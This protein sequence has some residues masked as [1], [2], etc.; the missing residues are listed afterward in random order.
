MMF[1][2][3]TFLCM[4]HHPIILVPGAFRSQLTVT[5]E[6]QKKFPQC[7]NFTNYPFWISP[8]FLLPNKI[9]G[10]LYWLT[11]DYDENSKSII[12][13]PNITVKALDFG[14]VEGIKSTGKLFFL[15]AG[16]YNRVIKE[17]KI[18]NYVIGKNLF[19]APYDWRLGIA[20][21]KEF[22]TNLTHLVESAYNS[23]NIKVKFLTHSCGGLILHKFLTTE[24]TPEWRK[25]YIDSAVLSAPSFAGSGAS[26]VTL[27]RQRIPYLKF[28]KNDE[29]K[30]MIG[31]L[32]AFHLHIPNQ[33]IYENTTVFI[34]PENESIKA[35]QVVDF[36]IQHH[37]LT[38]KQQKIALENF[39]YASRFPTALDIPVMIQY[40]SGI[41]T[42]FGLNI[43]KWD[44]EGQIIYQKGDGIV[45]SEGIERICEQWKKEG[46]DIECFDINSSSIVNRHPFLILRSRPVQFLVNWL[47]NSTSNS[48]ISNDL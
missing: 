17:L 15:Q 10:L 19:G 5:T 43:T 29:L 33:K 39:D 37:K 27:Y 9:S 25:K 30:Q 23:T 48:R 45:M 24:T 2:L 16:Y 13:Q 1:Y 22:W 47:L 32:G 41:P 7:P 12:D 14:G 3:F 6:F 44:S 40:N 31:S 8:K 38:S 20:Q 18:Y 36:L 11:L 35:S 28:F 46:T 21:K 26:L 42:A 34:T 4:I